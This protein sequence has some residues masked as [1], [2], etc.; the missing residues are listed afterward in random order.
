MVIIECENNDGKI[1][2]H[3][4]IVMRH[5]GECSKQ[6]KYIILK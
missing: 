6:L 1:A 5:N 4:S 3:K 2:K